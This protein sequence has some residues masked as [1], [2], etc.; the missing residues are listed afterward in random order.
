[1]TREAEI[2]RIFG[3]V[4]GGGEAVGYWPGGWCSWLGDIGDGVR[5]AVATTTLARNLAG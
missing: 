1:M 2:G 5:R 4:A 3:F